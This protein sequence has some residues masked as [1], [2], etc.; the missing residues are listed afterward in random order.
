MKL[1]C[2]LGNPGREFEEHRHNIG[3]KVVEALAARAQTDLGQNKFE[4][5]L[6]FGSLGREKLLF[7]EPQTFMNLSGRPLLA[8]LQFYK[9]DWADVLVI[10]D[11]LDLPF[12]RL[13]LKAGG[14][15]GGHNG[16]RSILELPGVD[17]FARLRFGVGKPVGDNAK[18]RVVGH[19]L[20]AFSAEEKV[21]L[22]PLIVASVEAAE[23]WA[24]EGLA[25]AMN[26]FNRAR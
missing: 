13:Q 4:A 7:L 15:A 11:E 22:G 9:L 5:R 14:G 25:T 20:G 19:V 16:L 18:D 6:G 26:R 21:A 12:G 23:T 24:R 10:H 17:A 1:I 3:F 8:V 2:G